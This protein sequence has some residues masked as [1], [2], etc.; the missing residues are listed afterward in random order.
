MRALEL[1]APIPRQPHRI[2]PT[3]IEEL[4]GRSGEAPAL[5]SDRDRLTY[6]ALN[7]SANRYARWALAQGLAKGDVVA[8]LMS[9]CPEYLAIWLGITSIGGVVALLNTNLEGASLSLHR[10]RIA[11]AFDRRFGT[12]KF[13]CNSDIESNLDSRDLDPRRW[14]F[15][16]PSD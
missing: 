3:V 5:L 12:R 11:K 8:L 15:F 2:F 6:K 16:L 1:T 13:L 4:A 10:C 14:P 7:Q 9:N